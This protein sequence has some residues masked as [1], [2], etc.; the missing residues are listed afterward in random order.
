MTRRNIAHVDHRGRVSLASFGLADTD[1]VVER[2]DD[3]SV[4]LSPAVV[5]TAA[6][7]RHYGSTEA[8]RA[9][10][11]GLASFADGKVSSFRLR[12]A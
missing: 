5:L 3:G 4:T 7:A 6:E 2:S 10:A 11:D 9:L 8:Q 1:V 12:R